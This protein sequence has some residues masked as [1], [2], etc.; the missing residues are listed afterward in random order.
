MFIKKHKLHFTLIGIALLSIVLVGC[1][2]PTYTT[3]QANPYYLESSLSKLKSNLI[4]NDKTQ[5]HYIE[6]Q[7]T[8]QHPVVMIHGTP[9]S[10]ESFKYV[11]GNTKL[12][13]KNHLISVDRLDWGES[14][15]QLESS[16]PSFKL[17]TEAIKTIIQ[18]ATTKPVILVGH[19]LGAS[20]A[21]KIAMDNPDLVAGLILVSGTLNPELGKPRWYNKVAGLWISKW[22]V[23]NNLLKSNDEIYALKDGLNSM[24]DNWS[25]L[26]IPVVVIQGTKDK[27]VDPDNVNYVK[28]KLAHLGGKLTIV[29]VNKAGH[30]IPWEHTEKI[31]SAIELVNKKIITANS[32]QLK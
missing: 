14:Q 17:Q 19:S 16:S 10:W 32:E 11:L 18:S 7:E 22:L 25:Q 3:A 30:F 20:L 31:V 27:L 8:D 28:K 9:G 15:P 29:E 24:S 13:P 6:V 23:P 4:S 26:K 1:G 2:G 12:Q 5:L 21:P